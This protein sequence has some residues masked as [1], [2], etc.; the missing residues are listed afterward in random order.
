MLRKTVCSGVM[1]VLLGIHSAQASVQVPSYE[2]AEP[3]ASGSIR[4]ELDML[5]M[6]ESLLSEQKTN[7][8]LFSTF[9]GSDGGC[10]ESATITP[11]KAPGPPAADA[12]IVAEPALLAIWLIL[13][14]AGLVWCRFRA[15]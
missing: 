3:G 1:C 15:A 6:P 7:V 11:A 2:P 12:P 8:L 9:S 4:E 10:E 13:G 14:I 5:L